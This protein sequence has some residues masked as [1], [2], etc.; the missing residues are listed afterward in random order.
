MTLGRVDYLKF[1]FC[2][3][4][5]ASTAPFSEAQP[6]RWIELLYA[7]PDEAGLP[8]NDRFRRTFKGYVEWGTRVTQRNSEIGFTPPR[9][10]HVPT[11]DSVD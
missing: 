6:E 8:G 2:N 10:A 1:D 11:W 7:L 3:L 9:D 4:M 5:P